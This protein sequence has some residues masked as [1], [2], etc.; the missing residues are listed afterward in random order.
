MNP[1][2]NE[3]ATTLHSRPLLRKPVLLLILLGVMVGVVLFG[4]YRTEVKTR[5]VA[6]APT[7]TPI[8]TPTPEKVLKRDDLVIPKA[9]PVYPGSMASGDKSL[10]YQTK[11][12]VEKVGAYYSGTISG[13]SCKST[14][15]NTFTCEKD[16][17]GVRAELATV[18]GFTV[19]SFSNVNFGRKMFQ[20]PG[21]LFTF[22]YPPEAMVTETPVLTLTQP[23]EFVMEFSGAFGLG[24]K[25]LETY[26]REKEKQTPE[27]EKVIQNTAP[28]QAG[29]VTGFLYITQHTTAPEEPVNHFFFQSQKASDTYLE[30][31]V[32]FL[33][34]RTYTMEVEIQTILESLSFTQ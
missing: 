31:K 6:T 11:D 17:I 4:I 5:A 24:G 32:R 28:V 20:K 12:P 27:N 18:S 26:V 21:T 13:W 19:I 22:L 10:F 16:G 30:I 34:P 25:T 3:Q 33:Q 23:K 14:T 7:A 2:G 15:P 29:A 8:P 9:I 1:A